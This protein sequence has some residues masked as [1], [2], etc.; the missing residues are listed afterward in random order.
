M[1]R[2]GR[3][4]EGYVVGGIQQP[5]AT[6]FTE[7]NKVFNPLDSYGDERITHYKLDPYQVRSLRAR[8]PFFDDTTHDNR[9]HLQKTGDLF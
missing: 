6:G 4:H 1:N 7:N 8:D 9:E 2:K 3:D 5:R